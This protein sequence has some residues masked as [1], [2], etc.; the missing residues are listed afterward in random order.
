MPVYAISRPR[1]FCGGYL[2]L[3]LVDRTLVIRCP[4]CGK[5]KSARDTSTPHPRLQGGRP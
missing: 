2:Q 3:F 5:E 4:L 1:C